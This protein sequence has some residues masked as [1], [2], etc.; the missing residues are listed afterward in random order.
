[1]RKLLYLFLTCLLLAGCR[2]NRFYLDKVEALW[3]ADYDSVQHYLLKVDSASLTPEDALDYHYFRMKASY[4]Y[5]MAMDKSQ[6]DAM[7]RTMKECYPK[8]HERAFDARF[9]Q[10]VYYYSRLDD[11]KVADG[12]AD[13]LRGYI[14]NRRDSSFWYRYKYLLKFYQSE[15]D[16]ALH[17]L[18]EAAKFRLFNEARIYSLRGDLYQ[19]KQQADSAVSCYL[20]AMELDSVTPMFQLA[21]LVVDLLPQQKDTKKALELL[22]RIRERIKRADIPYYNLIKGDFWLAMHEPD[23][24]M[25]HYRIATETGNGFIVSQAYERMGMIA[26]SRQ[27]DEETFRMY[28]KA[29]RVWND[30][31]FSLEHVKDTRDFEALK[32]KNQLNELEV[33]RQKH[34]ILILGLMMFVFILIGGFFFYLIHRKRIN[35]RNRLM[36]ENV[37]LKQQEELSNLREK[38][39]LMREKDAR[40]REE[41][42]KR[43]NV[44]QKL[45][46][47]EKEKHIQLS[48]TDWKE[49]QLMLDSG[50]DDFTKKLRMQVPLLSEKDINFCCLVKINMS[51]Q[52]LT[53]IY[54]ISKN[55]VS[56]KKLRLKDKMGIG[57]GDTMDEFLARIG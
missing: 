5:L 7:I 24:A 11:M 34:V 42:F 57:E 41:L 49:I 14:R 33:E 30:I 10:L 9:L 45:S 4:A 46:D 26:E 19:T 47:T 18:N 6:L 51:S 8:G 12:L 21:R 54:C 25:R 56:R 28:H 48:D 36:Q 35:E 27:T 1:M 13:E 23:S 29:Q 31:Y 39:A 44:F 22:A 3:G 53:D 17:Y 40:M 15:G 50:Y 37:L 2:G 55:S 20:M 43:I 32:M 52:N 16:S 38:E